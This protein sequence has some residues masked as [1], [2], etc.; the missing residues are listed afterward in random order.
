ME[1]CCCHFSC[2]IMPPE[3]RNYFPFPYLKIKKWLPCLQTSNLCSVHENR[4]KRRSMATK[5][6]SFARK[7]Q[8][9][10]RTPTT[11]PHCRLSH[12]YDLLA[13]TLSH[14]LPYLQGKLE[15]WTFHL[16]KAHATISTKNWDTVN[17]KIRKQW[18]FS[19]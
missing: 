1:S 13:W 14:G 19:E 7:N 16:S 2:S 8:N 18:I 9:I 12:L 4:R 11:Q 3:T 6:V 17:K 10:P 15:K 5:S